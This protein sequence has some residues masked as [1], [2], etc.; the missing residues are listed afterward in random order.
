MSNDRI[1]IIGAGV[2]GTTLAHRLT[3]KGHPV[4]AVEAQAEVGGLDETLRYDGFSPDGRPHRFYSASPE[5]KELAARVTPDELQSAPMRMK[6]RRRSKA[7][8]TT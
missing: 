6:Q 8:Q 5:V 3:E 7:D 2:C 4:T 1:L